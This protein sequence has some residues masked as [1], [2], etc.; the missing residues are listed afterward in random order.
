MAH[1]GDEIT[2]IIWRMTK[3]K[4]RIFILLFFVSLVYELKLSFIVKLVCLIAAYIFPNVDFDTKYFDLGIWKVL[5]PLLRKYSG[6]DLANWP[7]L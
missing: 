7:F 5:K 6:P 1:L 4:V 2:S 3:E